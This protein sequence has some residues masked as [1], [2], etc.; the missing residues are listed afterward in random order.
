MIEFKEAII[1]I[2]RT[3]RE[4]KNNKWA[5][6]SMKNRPKP[7]I[8][9]FDRYYYRDFIWKVAFSNGLTLIPLP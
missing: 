8:L 9:P 6:Q 4:G 1:N 5:V 2:R 7:F 3:L